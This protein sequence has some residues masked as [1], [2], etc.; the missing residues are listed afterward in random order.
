[1]RTAA[2]DHGAL[3]RGKLRGQRELLRRYAVLV[4]LRREGLPAAAD[5]LAEAT[6]VTRLAQERATA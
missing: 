4:L 1:V 2:A 3:I 6:L 5:V